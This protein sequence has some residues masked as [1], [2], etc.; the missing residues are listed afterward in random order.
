MQHK[1][2][3]ESDGERTFVLVLDASERTTVG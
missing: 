3:L 2:V 1:L